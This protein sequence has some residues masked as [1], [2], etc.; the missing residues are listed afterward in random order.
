[1]IIMMTLIWVLFVL[2][3][4]ILLL[5]NVQL[6]DQIFGEFKRTFRPTPKKTRKLR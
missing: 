3:M 2:V 5:F 1:M 6:W 4:C